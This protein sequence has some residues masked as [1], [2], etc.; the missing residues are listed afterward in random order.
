MAAGSS[1]VALFLRTADNRLW[2]RTLAGGGTGAWSTLPIGGASPNGPG[3]VVTAGDVVHLVV[4]GT[5]GAVY[6]ATRRGTTW[7][8]WESLG[9][10]IQG[11]PAVAVRPGGGIAI[12]ARG[13]NNGV[14]ANFGD[15]GSWTG[16]SRLPGETLTSPDGRVGLPGRSPGPVRRRH[17]R[18]AVSEGV[19][20]R[21]MG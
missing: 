20:E 8:G 6:H 12:V 16:W 21:H 19:L 7:S 2:Q 13:T 10:A 18:G 1:F 15:T 14:Y 17:D 9:G 4:R 5:N 11:T 3:A